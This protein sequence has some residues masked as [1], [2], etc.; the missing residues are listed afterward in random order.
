MNVVAIL[1]IVAVLYICAFL[2]QIWTWLLGG[3]SWLF[4]GGF[5][6]TFTNPL[7][8]VV[9]VIGLIIGIYEKVMGARK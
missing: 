6:E 2:T 9:L 4:S 5:K 3:P 8:I 1:T 7:V